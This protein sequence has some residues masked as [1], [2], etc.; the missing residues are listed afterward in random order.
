MS[1]L[2][3]LLK[4]TDGL[5]D[6]VDAVVEKAVAAALKERNKEIKA[7]IKN[8]KDAVKAAGLDKASKATALLAIDGVAEELAS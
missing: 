8:A 2:K 7:A 4:T 6:E 5:Q 3:K 1:N